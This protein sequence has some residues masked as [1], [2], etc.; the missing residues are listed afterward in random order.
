MAEEQQ[1][2]PGVL[3]DAQIRKGL[4]NVERTL[5]GDGYAFSKLDVSGKGIDSLG[6]SL[7]R[8]QHVRYLNLADN[9]VTDLTPAAGMY[10][11]LAV[12]AKNNKLTA[13]GDLSASTF[14]QVCCMGCAR[15]RPCARQCWV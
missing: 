9:A 10:S 11:L 14:L 15:V 3:S 2:N 7:P 8:F 5:D 4:S 13:I 1:E 12:D 6:S